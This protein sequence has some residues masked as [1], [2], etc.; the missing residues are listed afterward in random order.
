MYSRF[1]SCFFFG[2][3]IEGLSKKKSICCNFYHL[4]YS[5]YLL[6]YYFAT[7]N[8]LQGVPKVR[9]STL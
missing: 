4:F 1:T 3:V 5:F 9:S 6:F 2:I 8:K 7:Q